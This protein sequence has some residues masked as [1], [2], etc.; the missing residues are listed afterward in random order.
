MELSNSWLNGKYVI[1][2]CWTVTVNTSLSF[3][4]FEP[5]AGANVGEFTY[6]GDE[7]DDVINQIFEIWNSGVITQHEA[8]AKWANL[9]L[10]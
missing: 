2:G 9:Y 7:G 1:D 5:V 4:S 6:Q 3:I 8:V 10:Y